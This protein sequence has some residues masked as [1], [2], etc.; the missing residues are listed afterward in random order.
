M[1]AL[2]SVRETCLLRTWRPALRQQEREPGQDKEL[3]NL[4]MNAKGENEANAKLRVPM[5][6]IGADAC[7]LVLRQ[8]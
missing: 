7:V 3:E 1:T 5:L 2:I 4:S 6:W 8:L